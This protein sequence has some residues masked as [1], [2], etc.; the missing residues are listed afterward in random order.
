MD[1]SNDGVG[2]TGVGDKLVEELFTIPKGMDPALEA[3]LDDWTGRD[4]SP[5]GALAPSG[6]PGTPRRRP[7]P[8]NGRPGPETA[9]R[10]RRTTAALPLTAQPA[11]AK[12]ALPS[13]GVLP[14]KQPPVAAR[15]DRTDRKGRGDRAS[16][17]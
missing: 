1:L 17:R 7:S 9:S 2:I 16:S 3:R 11:S 12:S 10:D 4:P 6:V 8:Q 14:L 5:P 15:T 13:G